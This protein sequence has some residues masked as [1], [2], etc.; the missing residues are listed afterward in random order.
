L[1]L[2][3]GFESWLPDLVVGQIKEVYDQDAAI[4]QK[5]VVLPLIDYQKL[6]TVFII[7]DW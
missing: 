3:S 2:T 1:V 7:V 4:Y 6:A 5:A